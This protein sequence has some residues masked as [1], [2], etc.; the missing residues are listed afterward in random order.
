MK[1]V[2]GKQIDFNQTYNDLWPQVY[3]FIYYR[4]QNEEEAEELTQ[5]V[6][7]KVFKQIKKRNIDK[8][9]IAPYVFRAARNTVYDMWRQKGRRPKIIGIEELSEKGVQLEG[10][11]QNM[12]NNLIV[13]EALK[14]LSDDEQK[15]LK[16]RIIEG[17]KIEEV[18]EILN[19]PTGTVKSLQYRALKKLKDKLNEGGYFNE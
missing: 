8:D 14:Q 5:D 1:H 13:R 19:K 4:V 9:K 11:T 6:F 12:D 16:L 7:H 18:S 10:D 15:I 2:S 17:Y 3:K